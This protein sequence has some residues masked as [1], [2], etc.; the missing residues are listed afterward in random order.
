MRDP[1]YTQRREQGAVDIFDKRAPGFASAIKVH[2][3]GT[4]EAME[5][6]ERIVKM[7]N[8]GANA[9]QEANVSAA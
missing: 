1:Y 4:I 8:A 7:L 6:A 3:G 5:M 2:F 9:R